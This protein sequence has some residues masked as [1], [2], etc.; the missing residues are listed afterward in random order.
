MAVHHSKLRLSLAAP[1][2]GACLIGGCGGAASREAAHMLRGQKFLAGGDFAKA[3]VEF[4]NALQIA[5]N[6]AE[7]RYE[8]GVVDEKSGN[9]REAAQFYQGA[10]DVDPDDVLARV[11]LGRLYV[12]AGAPK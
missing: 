9:P 8:N 4:R 10:I 5:P 3:R 2:L 12:I 11:G 6:D 1:L 7:T